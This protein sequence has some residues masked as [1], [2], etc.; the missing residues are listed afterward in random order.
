V[1]EVSFLGLVTVSAVAFLVPLTLG[2][3]PRLRLPSVVLEI[4]AGIVIGPSGFG[5]VDP[6]LPIAILSVMGLGFLLFLA[7][8]EIELD[9]FMGRFLQKAVLGLVLSFALGIVVSYGLRTAGVVETPLFV[10]I[11]LLATGLGL[12]IP[13][14]RDAGESSTDFGQLTIA[15]SAFADFGAVILLSL[16]FSREATGPGAQILLLG[17][18]ALLVAVVGLS[19]ARAGRSML[20]SGALARLQDTTAQIRVRGAVVLMI[21]VVALAERLG[22]E[23]ILGSFVAGVVLKVIDRDMMSHPRFQ[24]KLDAIGYGFLVPIFFITSG[25]RFDLGALFASGSA[26]LRIPIFLLALLVVRGTPAFVY[27]P[28][29]GAQR[30]VAAAFLQ[31]TSLPFIVAATQI[32]MELGVISTATGASLVAAGL[33]SVL[34]FPLVGLSVLR[35]SEQRGGH[36]NKA[37]MEQPIS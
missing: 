35:R 31:A 19:I 4:V 16:F 24:S 11:V 29:V 14:L 21:G 6:D 28:L 32:G 25:L 18:F 30:A 23:V 3:N 9:R 10:A 7:G 12:V 26:I 34:L 2:L 37:A 33:L 36:S 13:L 20:I 5:W 1:P 17:G 27:G 8:L 15:G 22:L